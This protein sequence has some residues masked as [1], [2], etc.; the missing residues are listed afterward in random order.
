MDLKSKEIKIVSIDSIQVNPKNRNI[1]PEDQIA[2]L[3]E[4]IKEE[5]F[6]V[7]LVI[8]NRTGLLVAGHGRLQAARM[9]DLK[10]LPVIFQD[11]DSEEQEYRV[12]IS[13]NAI[14]SWAVLDFSTIH[15]DLPELSPFNLDLLGIKNFNLEPPDISDFTEEKSEQNKFEVVQCPHCEKEFE[16]GQAKVKV[17]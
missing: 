2:R 12:G 7:P 15:Q 1:H 6:R 16:L 10:E 11:F 13:D 17:V 9:L 14:A 8:S 5:G 4:I 3:A